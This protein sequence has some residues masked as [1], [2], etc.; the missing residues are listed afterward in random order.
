MKT[1][2]FA[3][4]A[5]LLYCQANAQPADSVKH[6]PLKTLTGKEYNALIKGEDIYGMARAAEMNHYPLP[7]KVLTY[8]REMNLGPGQISKIKAIA[9]E[10]HRKKL[11]MGLII[12]T[13]ERTIDSLFRTNK[14]NN[15]SLIFYANRYGLYMGEIRNAILQA[16]LATH[17]LLSAGQIAKLEALQ[18]P[19]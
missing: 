9:K 10:L 6:S 8:K 5:V 3:L 11:E 1:L 17:Y 19:D 13:N 2:L 15:G 18:K 12:I 7:D 16:C 4:M 14:F